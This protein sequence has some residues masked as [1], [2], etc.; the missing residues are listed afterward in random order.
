MFPAV[1]K[2]AAR[3][4]FRCVQW[5]G[6]SALPCTAARGI[7]VNL[8]ILAPAELE[9]YLREPARRYCDRLKQDY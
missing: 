7:L 5:S 4:G 9:E 1:F 6:V 2:K 3:L 8:A